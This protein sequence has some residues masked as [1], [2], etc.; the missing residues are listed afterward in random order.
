MK[1]PTNALIVVA[2]G[3]RHL[4]LEACAE[5]P[6]GLRVLSVDEHETIRNADAGS[7][8][9]GRFPGGGARREA[10]EETDA[11]RLGK[12]RFAHALAEALDAARDRPLILIADPRTLGALRASMTPGTAARVAAE[13]ATDLTGHT[14]GDI[15]KAIEKA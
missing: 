15:A 10:V 7:D 9:P 4:L 3:S 6:T 1:L 14:V 5:T 8:R 13:I 12:E 2:D 11:K